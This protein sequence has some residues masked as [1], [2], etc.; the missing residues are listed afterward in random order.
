MS[1][2]AETQET[3]HYHRTILLEIKLLPALCSP[4]FPVSTRLSSMA[5]TAGHEDF[6]D[7]NRIRWDPTPV[8]TPDNY[9]VTLTIKKNETNPFSKGGAPTQYAQKEREAGRPDDKYTIQRHNATTESTG[10]K[11]TWRDI[12]F[13]EPGTWALKLVSG[14]DQHGR[15]TEYTTATRFQISAGGHIFSHWA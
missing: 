6:F 5:T 3:Q 4:L 12:H 10:N 13:C 9:T 2:L 11:F 7:V 14:A 15:F 8:T 1:Q